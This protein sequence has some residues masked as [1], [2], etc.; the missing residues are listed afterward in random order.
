MD[1]QF[2]PV[3]MSNIARA[4]GMGVDPS[5]DAVKNRA[6]F[7]YDYKIDLEGLDRGAAFDECFKRRLFIKIATP[8]TK[9]IAYLPATE[10]H[11]SLYA[12][13][14]DAFLRKDELERRGTP[15]WSKREFAGAM[16]EAYGLN[17]FTIEALA[18]FQNASVL[19][20]SGLMIWCRAA[21]AYLE[22]KAQSEPM[23]ETTTISP[24]RR[25]RRP[26]V[27]DDHDHDQGNH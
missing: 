6:E 4:P 3:Q 24:K 19:E 23:S 5:V 27:R 1:V 17:I 14:Y 12:R 20:Q 15:L 10:M 18:E 9:D 22:G 26:K 2:D 21:K 8:A 25:G 16:R 11:K 7:M 13:Q